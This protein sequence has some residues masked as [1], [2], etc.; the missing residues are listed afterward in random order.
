M[1][2]GCAIRAFCTAMS[3]SKHSQTCF[4]GKKIC[5][6]DV[7]VAASAQVRKI[8]ADHHPCAPARRRNEIPKVLKARILSALSQCSDF[9]LCNRADD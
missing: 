1:R 5:I 4:G 3:R 8:R 6:V 2:I 9:S 7:S